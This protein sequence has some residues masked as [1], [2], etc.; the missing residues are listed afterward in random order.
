MPDQ[1]LAARFHGPQ[2]LHLENVNRPKPGPGWVIVE[3]AAV[4]ICGTDAHIYAGDF[5]VRAPVTLGHEIAGR[6]SEV[7]EGIDDLSVGDRVCVEPHVFCTTCVYCRGGRE[8]LCLNKLAFGVHLD[9]G[10]AE[11]VAVPRRTVYRIPDGIDFSIAALAEPVACSVHGFDRLAPLQ[12]ESLLIIG[13]GPAGL[14]NTAL[15]IHK[16]T[17]PVVVIE[18]DA[19]RRRIARDFGADLTVDPTEEGWEE[20]AIAVTGG[21]GFNNVI[22]AVGGGHTLEAGVRLAARG[23]KIL[24]FGVARENEIA[25]LRP[26]DIFVRELT[27]LGTVINPY[28]QA[29][30]VQLLGRLPLEKLPIE[31]VPLTNV[32]AAFDGSL[33]GPIKV[34]IRPG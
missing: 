19:T 22:E 33:K 31:T 12:G 27:L 26:Y 32:G 5:P 23:A 25:R 29:R 4:G 11:A 2:V 20:Q 21:A 14:I 10:M 34:Q 3:P 15:A 8:H 17:G 30:A 24:V 16:G 18:P 7:G 6:I 28:T 13:G 9:G 1:M